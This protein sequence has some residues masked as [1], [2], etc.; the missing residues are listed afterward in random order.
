MLA[1]P[2]LAALTDGRP[3][4]VLVH[5]LLPFLVL[6]GHRGAPLVERRRHGVASSSRSS[7]RASPV[8]APVLAVLLVVVGGRRTRAAIVRIV[9]IAIPAAALFAPL[10]FWQLRH[11]TPLALLADPGPADPG[12]EPARAG[13]CCSATRR[14]PTTAGRGVGAALGLPLATARSRRAARA[15][16]RCSRCSPSSCPGARRAIPALA[17]A[18]GGLATAV[19]AT[20]LDVAVAGSEAVTPW[21][22]GA[23]SLYWLGLVGAA[24]VGIDAIAPAGVLDRA[25]RAA[26]RDRRGRAAARRAAARAA[27]PW[28]PARRGSCPPWSTPRP[29]PIRASAP[30]S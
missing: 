2:L 10:V 18:L 3:A 26:R 19:V 12:R 30:S 17:V 6:A 20:H 15:A 1:P 7:S 29:T 22:G 23:L 8:M 14:P 9:G 5:L 16:R 24:V 28:S 21:A 27:R 11:G 13:C 4:G 25:D